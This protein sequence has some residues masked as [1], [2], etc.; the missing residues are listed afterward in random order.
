MTCSA[1]PVKCGCELGYDTADRLPSTTIEILHVTA[2]NVN[3]A[4]LDTDAALPT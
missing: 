2:S 3:D 1:A 4:S